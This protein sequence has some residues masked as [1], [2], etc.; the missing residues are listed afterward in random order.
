MNYKKILLGFG[1]LIS[2]TV[3][4]ALSILVLIF[5]PTF[6]FSFISSWGFVWFIFVGSILLGM[7]YTGL[8]LTIQAFNWLHLFG[9]DRWISASIVSTSSIW[10]FYNIYYEVHKSYINSDSFINWTPETIIYAVVITPA[11]IY[12]LFM[13]LVMPFL[14]NNRPAKSGRPS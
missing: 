11:F 7:Y 1:F 8:T 5:L 12:I 10:T 6:L 3:G 13:F 9:P 2:A 14:W 4:V